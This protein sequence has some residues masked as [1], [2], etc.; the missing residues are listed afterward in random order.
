MSLKIS[1]FRL[2][3]FFFS[4]IGNN[5]LKNSDISD[6]ILYSAGGVIFSNCEALWTYCEKL[7]LI[8]FTTHK[9]TFIF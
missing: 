5:F 2:N 8:H 3:S 4:N 9:K 1:L 6:N 7:D